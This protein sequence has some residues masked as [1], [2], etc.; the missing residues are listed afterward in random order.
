VDE[1]YECA[2][3]GDLKDTTEKLDIALDHIYIRLESLE[4][5]VRT[6]SKHT[7]K[8]FKLVR[9][10]LWFVVFVQVLLYFLR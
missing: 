3:R 5:S 7:V 8:V 9:R 2:T 6:N 4:A 1:D 10:G